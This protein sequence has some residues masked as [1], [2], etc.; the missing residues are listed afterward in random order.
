ML[1]MLQGARP[2]GQ[3]AFLAGIL[4]PAIAKAQT[5]LVSGVDASKTGAPIFKYIYRHFLENAGNQC[6]AK[7]RCRSDRTIAWYFA[8]AITF[9]PFSVMIHSYPIQ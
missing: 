7:A 3:N 8:E 4:L 9:L 1:S 6:G 2:T 5:K